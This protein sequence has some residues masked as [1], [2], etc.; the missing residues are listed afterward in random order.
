MNMYEQS[1]ANLIIAWKRMNEWNGGENVIGASVIE[2]CAVYDSSWFLFLVSW[3][4]VCVNVSYISPFT[5]AIRTNFKGKL[6]ALP[7][8]AHT[9]SDSHHHLSDFQHSK[10]FHFDT[11]A[12]FLSEDCKI[13][14]I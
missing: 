14:A 11:A 12:L 4:Y 3:F 6:I 10:C 2:L 13:M 5:A 9:H 7:V 8:S 1:Q